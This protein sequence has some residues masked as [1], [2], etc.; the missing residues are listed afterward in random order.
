MDILYSGNT[1]TAQTLALFREQAG[2]HVPT[3]PQAQKALQNTLYSVTA[4]HGGNVV[5]IGRLVGDG[6]L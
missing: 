3:I 4:S 1:L 2:W 6:A 5:G